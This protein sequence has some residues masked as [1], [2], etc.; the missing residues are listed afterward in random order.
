MARRKQTLLDSQTARDI[1]AELETYAKDKQF[2]PVQ[3]ALY[4]HMHRKLDDSKCRLYN[5][6]TIGKFDYWFD[7]LVFEG[8]IDID[9]DTRAIRAVRLMIVDRDDLPEF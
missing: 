4:G 1:L 9:D 7:R 2:Y 5:E 3:N 6:L 8:Y